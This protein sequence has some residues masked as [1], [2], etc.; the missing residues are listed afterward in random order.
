MEN[1]SNVLDN[2]FH[3]LADP[4]RRAVVAQLIEGDATVKALA[5]PFT[6][7]LPTFMKHLKVLEDSGLITTV[8]VGRVRTCRLQPKQLAQVEDWLSEQRTHWEGRIDRL[9]QYV[10]NNLIEE[11]Q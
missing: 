9:A 6:I 8:K 1:Y 10:E 3:A 7:G 5:Q 11:E 2:A 4:T